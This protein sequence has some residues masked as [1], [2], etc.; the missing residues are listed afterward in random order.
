M[1]RLRQLWWAMLVAAALVA[2][3]LYGLSLPEP[4]AAAVAGRA[5]D[6]RS[7]SASVTVKA[8]GVSEV[9]HAGKA[10][11]AA[12]APVGAAR[13]GGPGEAAVRPAAATHPAAGASAPFSVSPV[14]YSVTLS[15]DALLPGPSYTVRGFSYTSPGA[16]E[17]VLL[18]HSFSFGY[19]QWDFPAPSP[20]PQNPYTYSTAR[21]LAAHGID[22]VAI[23]VLGV[24]SS[25][26]PSGLDA[27]QLTMPAYA[28]MAHQIVQS[29]RSRYQQVVAVGSSTGGEIANIE[30][31]R[32]QD[33]DGVADLDF[34]DLP[35]ISPQLLVDNLGP[36]LVGLVQPYVDFEGGT[37]ARDAMFYNYQDADVAVMAQSDALV[38]RIA[39]SELH[40]AELQLGRVLDPLVKVPVLV[41][42]GQQDGAWLPACQTAQAGLYLSSPSVTTFIL[43]G[44]GH[45]LMLHRNAGAFES[46][47]LRWLVA[48]SHR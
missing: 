9:S 35:L 26:R 15:Q 6:N 14:S 46:E 20:D 13:H 16:R 33:V 44:A 21:Y 19:Q 32:Y 39:S 29:L 48:V 3:G 43:P 37:A 31:G 23:D 2:G 4:S 34:C 40:T 1:I 42:F 7:A 47:L 22:A 12:P 38:Q 36:T 18:L 10:P 25:D 11:P 24:G 30:A 45:A 17:V 5:T 41:A 27:L 8:A 28:S